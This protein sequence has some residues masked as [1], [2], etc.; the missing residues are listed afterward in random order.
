MCETLALTQ[1]TFT[2]CWYNVSPSSQTLAKYSEQRA[3]PPLLGGGTVSKAV[4]QQ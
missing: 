4:A 3:V 2:Q 1:K